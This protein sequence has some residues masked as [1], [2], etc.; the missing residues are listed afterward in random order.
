MLDVATAA[1][2]PL[3]D[4]S[5]GLSADFF[6]E[7][8]AHAFGRVHQPAAEWLAK[9]EPEDV[10]LPGLE[11]VDCHHHLW[12]RPSNR[13]ALEEVVA[14]LSSGHRV[15]STVVVEAG[16]HYRTRGSDELK[17]V[18][19]TE[20]VHEIAERAQ[21][22]P[23]ISTRIGA[24]FV[25]H[26][27]LSLG[28]SIAPVLD[29]HLAASPRVR[30]VRYLTSWDADPSIGVPLTTRPLMLRDTTVVEASRIV[31]ERSLALDVNVF[32]HQLDDVVFLAQKVPE[33]TI[34]LGHV[35]TPLGYGTYQGRGHEVAE[36]WAQGMARVAEVPNVVVKLGGMMMRL[37]AYDYRT[38]PRPATSDELSTAWKPFMSEAIDLFGPDRC[39]FE[40]NFP[41][42]KMG[43]TYRT[44]WNA[45]KRIA[46]G[47][48]QDELTDLFAGT[49][50]RVYRV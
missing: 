16:F 34:V 22:D 32:F 2:G 33:L 40:S 44:V 7:G 26:A 19:E 5:T 45:F 14:D 18:G 3:S 35:G 10:L 25:A 49:A 29:A 30:G 37:A 13:Y 9:S 24:G 31:A 12:D 4:V 39:A 43:G 48:S 1:E 38:A 8:T 15:T 23:A 36:A 6:V 46:A 50:K 28:S 42:E 11:I 21:A 41:V 17:P 27:D 20:F 47:G